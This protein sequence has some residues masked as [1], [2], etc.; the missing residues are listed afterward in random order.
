MNNTLNDIQRPYL[1][2]RM[3]PRN[4]GVNRLE[5]QTGICGET[6]GLRI[7]TASIHFGE[8]PPVTGTGGS[9]TIFITGCNLRCS[10]CQ[11]YQIS[12][13]KM[14]KTVS[15]SEFIDICLAL[16]KK[17]AENINIVTGT[18][19]IPVLTDYLIGAKNSGLCIPILWNTSSYENTESLEILKPVIDGYLPDLK[20]LDT[21]ISTTLFCCENYPDKAKKA[22][23][24]MAEHSS[25]VIM[26]HL[27]LPDNLSDTKNVLRWFSENLSGKAQLSLMTQFTPVHKSAHKGHLNRYINQ[28]EF[29]IIQ[30][31]IDEFDI[32]DGFYQ[33]LI[34]DSDWL[35]D[36]NRTN[37]FSSD[38]SKPIWHWKNGFI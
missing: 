13:E 15:K 11:N 33:E 34:Q 20:T 10:F 29:D 1:H 37:P 7:A 21:H 30:L 2:C 32:E 16:Q 8:E 14:G 27:V 38:L 9:G 36:F 24:W 17:G 28:D 35:P 31:M 18:H 26:R 4:C 5:Q 6:Y 19:A 22:I 12:Q 23:L 25:F 3:C